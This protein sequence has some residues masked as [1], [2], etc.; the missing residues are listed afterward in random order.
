[1]ENKTFSTKQR[2]VKCI[3][4]ALLLYPITLFA[5]YGQI[6]VKG[7]SLSVKEAI[8]QIEKHS[9]Y[10]FFYNATLLK[11]MKKK[12]IDCKGSIE[13]VMN[14]IFKNTNVEYMINGNEVVLKVKN[15]PEVSQQKAQKQR[16]ITGTVTDANTNETL[17]GANVQVK[18]QATGTITDL[19]G[20]YSITVYSSKDVLVV[21]YMGYKTVE[22][23]VEDMGVLN[24]ALPSDTELLNEVVVVGFGTQ[25]KVS[26]VGSVTNIKAEALKVPTSSLTNSFAGRLAGVITTTSSGEPGQNAS[27]FY[28]RG[29]GTFGGRATPLIMLDGVEISAADL[30]YIPAES[31]ESFSIL[32]DAS[33]TAVYGARG[34]NGVMIV[35]TKVGSNNEKTRINVSI[36]NSFN[37]PTKY[38]EFADGVKYMEMFNE[39][40]ST[41]NG[42]TLT[43]L[44]YSTEKIDNTRAGMNPYV[45]PN[46]DWR[47]LMFKDMSMSQRANLNVSGGGSKATYYLSLQ[48]NHDA[49]ALNTKKVYSFDNQ[50]NIWS[51]TFQS[52]IDYNI[53]STTKLGLRMNAQ[54]RNTVGPYS[55]SNIN[56]THI[57]KQ[58]L[59]VN[60]VDFPAEFPSSVNEA[61]A[62]HVLFG[63]AYLSGHERFNPYAYMLSY[64]GEDFQS[65]ILTTV[66]AEQKLDMITQGLKL[67]AMVS[68]KNWSRSFFSRSIEPYYYNAAAGSYDPYDPYADNYTLERIGTSGT[69]H[70]TESNI[71]KAGDRTVVFQASLEWQRQFNLHN[72]SAMFLYNQREY[73]NVIL[74][75]RNQGISGRFTYDYGQRYL[76]EANFGYNGTERLASGHRFEFF[77]SFAIG[78]VVSNEKFFEP[79][80]DKIT[81][82]KLRASWG[83][84]GNDETG[85]D[86]SPHFIYLNDVTLGNMGYTTGVDMNKTL[87][88]PTVNRYG[89]I[90]ATWERAEKVN[91]G[92]DLELFSKLSLVVDIFQDNRSNILMERQKWA[93]FLGYVGSKPWASIGKVKSKGIEIAMN[94]SENLNKDLTLD[95]RGTF[96]YNIAKLIYRD[97]PTYSN[98][99]QQHEGKSLNGTWGYVA[100][101]LFV[102]QADIDNSATQN[103]GSIVLPGDIKYKDLNNDGKIDATDQCE[104]SPYGTTPRIMYGV[105]ATLKWKKFD[106]GVFFQ[107][108]AKRTISINDGIHPF[109]EMKANVLK[110]IAD[111]YW[112]ESN[113]NPEASY[114]R[115]SPTAQNRSENNNAASSYW[116]RD[117]SYVRLKNA[118]I[119]YTFGFG[120]VYVTGNN[121]L[122]FS[123]FKHWDPEVEHWYSYPMSRTVNVGVQFNF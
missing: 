34:A 39:A 72:L 45:Y 94:Y 50:V 42:G 14:E 20:N 43:G 114:P 1:M 109:G 101:R 19:D 25:K 51:Y 93:S 78:W 54:L 77:P 113:P 76:F 59:H 18:G 89:N 107:G 75:T 100:E 24:I 10:V 111:D 47:K 30:N 117:G 8:Q 15:A 48:A 5:A 119:G 69:D 106:I 44:P 98:E 17:V 105:G 23:T 49:G 53:T 115:L 95:L 9:N 40:T 104:L 99:W 35:T 16:T 62:D 90:E 73:R 122:T 57:F 108:A 66:S 22:K 123:P 27:N 83:L 70:I 88:G 13:E 31:I 112:S 60:P 55:D 7:E 80:N 71:E 21:S 29:I 2:Y 103:L 79:L 74:P 97:E 120:R 63:N 96:T 64:Y 85:G 4:L 82:L 36:E 56:T 110:F 87:N 32:K 58:M 41:R 12:N 11:E 116:L 6:T 65:T 52:N 67:K 118:E 61:G 38:P 28:I 26:V 81:N 86:A 121:L 37:M 46:V 68:F 102:D 84:V 92:L 91:I 33:A 3:I